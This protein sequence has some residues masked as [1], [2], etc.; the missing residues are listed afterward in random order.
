MDEIDN[1]NALARSYSR[2]KSDSCTS[3]V[4]SHRVVGAFRSFT[5]FNFEALF[6]IFLR[7][8]SLDS[9]ES[10]IA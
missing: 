8:I 3:S 10:T 6:F 5:K 1:L 2:P 7:R 9:I 4:I